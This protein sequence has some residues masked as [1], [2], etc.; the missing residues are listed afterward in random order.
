MIFLKSDSDPCFSVSAQWLH[1][2]GLKL[3][4][5]LIGWFP[6]H[7]AVGPASFFLLQ[8]LSYH[9]LSLTSFPWKCCLESYLENHP[10]DTSFKSFQDYETSISVPAEV[11]GR[12]FTCTSHLFHRLAHPHPLSIWIHQRCLVPTMYHQNLT[13]NFTSICRFFFFTI[14][15]PFWG[16]QQPRKSIGHSP[17]S[18][19]CFSFSMSLFYSH[20]PFLTPV[21]EIYSLEIN[22]LL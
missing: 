10:T 2:S 19:V 17:E 16:Y 14:H 7:D 5:I 15:T 21:S 6:W 13:W 9:L 3:W 12:Y 22:D 1:R 4:A 8:P 18:F 11:S 20:D